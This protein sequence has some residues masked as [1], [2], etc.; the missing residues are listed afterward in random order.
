MDELT[1]VLRLFAAAL[2]SLGIPYAIGGSV[3]STTC[4][5]VGATRN[6]DIVARVGPGAGGGPRCDAGPA[7][8]IRLWRRFAA[9]A[10]DK[11]IV[12]PTRIGILAAN[13]ALDRQYLQMW[14]ARLGV[15]GYL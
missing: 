6:T 9:W 15:S 5:V 7:T 2:E 3:A 8:V 1:N 4:G 12:C 10:D 11:T 14:A 13:P